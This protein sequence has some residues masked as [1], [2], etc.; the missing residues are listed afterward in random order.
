MKYL[1]IEIQTTAGGSVAQIVTIHD[2]KA[3]AEQKYHQVLSYAA[4]SDL[5]YHSVVI[6]NAKGEWEK[7]ETYNHTSINS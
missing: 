5:A 7:G 4:V 2:T 1:V 6:L 3:E